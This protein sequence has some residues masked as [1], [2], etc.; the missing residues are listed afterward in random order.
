MFPVAAIRGI[1]TNPPLGRGVPMFITKINDICIHKM[2]TEHVYINVYV[3]FVFRERPRLSISVY[4]ACTADG[5]NAVSNLFGVSCNKLRRIK[6][7]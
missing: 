3:S 7:L 1:I 5:Q 2:Y 6:L 4:Y